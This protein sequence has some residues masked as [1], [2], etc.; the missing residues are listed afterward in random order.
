M[1][2]RDDLGKTTAVELRSWV[3]STPTQ[4]ISYYERTTA[5]NCACFDS[6]RTKPLAMPMPYRRVHRRDSIANWYTEHGSNNNN[7]SLLHRCCCCSIIFKLKQ[8]HCY[9]Y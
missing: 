7:S 3:G 5:L 8:Y 6:C 1:E 9:Y 2:S 4:S